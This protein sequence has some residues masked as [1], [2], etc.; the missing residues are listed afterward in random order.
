MTV[1]FPSSPPH[2]SP[3]QIPYQYSFLPSSLQFGPCTWI[4]SLNSSS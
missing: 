3:C 4:L 2:P 1:V